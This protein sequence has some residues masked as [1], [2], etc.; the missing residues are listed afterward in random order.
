MPCYI[1]LFY[2]LFNNLFHI[3][4]AKNHLPASTRKMSEL[5]MLKQIVFREGADEG[6][7]LSFIPGSNFKSCPLLKSFLWIRYW[8][9]H[10]CCNILILF[11]PHTVFFQHVFDFFRAI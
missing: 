11:V 5:P 6:P 2:T 7:P 4:G 1:H 10:L 3:L 8:L 9:P